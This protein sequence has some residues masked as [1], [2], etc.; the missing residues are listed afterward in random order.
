MY[1]YGDVNL[2]P[3]PMGILWQELDHYF[4]QVTLS[5]PTLNIDDQD[6]LGAAIDNNRLVINSRPY[7]DSPFQFFSK[8]PTIG[9]STICSLYKIIKDTD[10]ILLR[11]PT[12]LSPL[13]CFFSHIHKKKIVCHIKGTWSGTLSGKKQQSFLE[14]NIVLPFISAFD[15]YHYKLASNNPTLVMGKEH[16]KNIQRPKYPLHII[17]VSIVSKKHIYWRDDTC[18]GAKIKILFVGR[19]APSKGL[20]HLI[21]A[22]EQLFSNRYEINIVGDGM[23]K[24]EIESLLKRKNMHHVKMLGSKSANLLTDIYIEHDIFILPSLNEGFPKVIYEA[25]A[26]GLPIITTKVGSI[27]DKLNH[28]ENAFLINPGSSSEIIRA[29]QFLSNNKTKRQFIIK[30]AYKLIENVTLEKS[31][32]NFAKFITENSN[33]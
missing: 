20:T 10:V 6:S 24:K 19:I 33:G 17:N 4:S 5:A 1:R 11:L 3:N 30:N 29:I 9:F 26:R 32:E 31:S 27:P 16:L 28:L 12:V 21:E 15:A 13:V 22:C 14:K 8:F 2:M 25:A 7:Y 18:K 23:Q